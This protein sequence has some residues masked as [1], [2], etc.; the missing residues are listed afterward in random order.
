MEKKVSIAILLL[1]IIITSLSTYGAFSGFLYYSSFFALGWW[2]LI[3]YINFRIKDKSFLITSISKLDFAYLF[4]ALFI[5]ILTGLMLEVYAQFITPIWVY[6][7]STLSEWALLMAA[8]GITTPMGFE[9]F[10]VVNNLMKGIK[11]TGKVNMGKKSKFLNSLVPTS[12]ILLFIPVIFF[13]LDIKI[14]PGLTF[15]FPL[16]GIWFLLDH[17]NYKKNGFCLLENIIRINP[18]VIISLLI[19]TLIMA[20]IGEVLNVPQKVWTYF[21]IP[22]LEYQ[23]LGVPYVILLGWLP[24]MIIWIAG[25]YA[26]KSILKRKYE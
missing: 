21:G 26:A 25:F 9:T 2:F 10:K 20:F 1:G 16:V 18:R 22:F 11:D 15:V 23:I 6:K 3:D 17:I 12:I 5:G 4:L 7:F 8:W 19:S 24:L 13:I 14:Y